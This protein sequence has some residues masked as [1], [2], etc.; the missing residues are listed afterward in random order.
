[1]RPGPI[2]SGLRRL[3]ERSAGPSMGHGIGRRPLWPRICRI[4][5]TA[6]FV[7]GHLFPVRW[8]PG[9][10]GGDDET[11]PTKAENGH[12]ER[13]CSSEAVREGTSSHQCGRRT[14]PLAIHFWHTLKDK[15]PLASARAAVDSV[16]LVVFLS[17]A[18]RRRRCRSIC[19]SELANEQQKARAEIVRFA[20]TLSANLIE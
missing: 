19:H 12:C 5:S 13:R 4:G 14:A 9:S 20:R 11:T 2:W 3:C 17:P 1:M 6:A 18:R 7:R 8:R 10:G 16:P 15:L